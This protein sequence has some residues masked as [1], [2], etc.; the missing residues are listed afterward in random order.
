[1]SQTNTRARDRESALATIEDET[2][3]G[4]TNDQETKKVRNNL[5][6][7]VLLPLPDVN[8]LWS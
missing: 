3:Q 7:L 8:S 4:L 2:I 5:F 6:E 1:M